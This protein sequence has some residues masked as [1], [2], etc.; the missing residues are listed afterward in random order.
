MPDFI[1]IHY[2]DNTLFESDHVRRTAS[3]STVHFPLTEDTYSFIKFINRVKHYFKSSGLSAL[4]VY[5]TEWNLTISHRDPINDTC[6]KACYLTKNLLENYDQL[7][8]FGYWCL[9]DFIEDLPLPNELY[10]GG[11]GMFTHNGIPKSHFNAFQFCTHLDD[12]LLAKGNGYFVTRSADHLAILTYNYEHY[13]RLF[14]LEGFSQGSEENRYHPFSAMSTAQFSIKIV[15]LPYQKCL[16]TETFVNQ[17]TGSSYDAWVRM[18][19][20]QLTKPAELE[21]LRQ[22]S[23]PGMYL[24]QQTIQDGVLILHTHLAPLEVRLIEVDLIP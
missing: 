11:L 1:N 5:L 20:Q 21:M 12:Q 18:G 17:T 4:P 22:Q 19:A 9:T 2:Y 16:V 3:Q 6:F 7:A 15:D 8:S 13:S 24:H 10:H 14:A 23:H